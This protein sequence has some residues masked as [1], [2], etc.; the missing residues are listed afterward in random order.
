VSEFLPEAPA[1]PTDPDAPA[2]PEPIKVHGTPRAVRPHGAGAAAAPLTV[3]RPPTWWRA[4]C[5][6]VVDPMLSKILRPHQREGVKFMYDC[7]T[8]R[9]V[10]GGRGCIMA[11]EMVRASAQA[12]PGETARSLMHPP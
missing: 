3:P 6:V 5:A 4:G 8:G 11:D 9:K 10:Q 12:I 2:P 1:P 7:V